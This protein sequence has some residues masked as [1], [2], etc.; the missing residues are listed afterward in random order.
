MPFSH[1]FLIQSQQFV[2]GIMQPDN[3]LL[4]LAAFPLVEETNQAGV[5][6]AV[7]LGLVM[8]NG[9]RD[10]LFENPISALPEQ[11]GTSCP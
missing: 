4:T 7:G 8:L 9:G 1:R 6:D 10:H 2:F 3:E 11:C 5:A